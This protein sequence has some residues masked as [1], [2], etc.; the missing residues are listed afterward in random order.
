MKKIL[1]SIMCCFAIS[2]ALANT[3]AAHSHFVLKGLSGD[4]GKAP[5]TSDAGFCAKFKSIAYCNCTEHDVPGFICEDM[6]VIKTMMVENYG[7]LENACEAQGEDAQECLVDWKY[8]DA[9]C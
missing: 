6:S 3:N 2:T 9:S 1:A 4:C 5:P 7:S 8:Y